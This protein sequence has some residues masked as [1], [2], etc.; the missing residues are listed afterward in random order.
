MNALDWTIVTVT[1]NSG[2]A[3]EAFWN[4]AR[5]GTE[6]RWV[7]VDNASA[8][9]SVA[10]AERLGADVLTMP[11]NVGFSAANNLGLSRA[12]TPFVGF[13]NPDISLTPGSLDLLADYLS[14]HDVL[15]APQLVNVDGSLQSNGRGLPYLVDKFAHRGLK[16][17]GSR[18]EEYLP[19]AG[20]SGEPW[21]AAWVMGAALT[22]RRS[23]WERLGAWDSRFFIYYEDHELGLRAWRQDVPVLVHDGVRWVHGWARETMRPSLSAWR[24]EVVSAARF[25]RRYPRLLWPRHAS[26]PSWLALKT[27]GADDGHVEHERW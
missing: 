27:G 4:Q 13:A 18:L 26:A 23:T 14:A 5:I 11:T 17:P 22:G 7:V 8:D 24:R 3:L 16:L 19:V 6:F 9:D 15:L 2:R 1:Y 25:Y 10:V 21:P 12:T 20:L